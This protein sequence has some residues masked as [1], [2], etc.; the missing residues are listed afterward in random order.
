MAISFSSPT[1]SGNSVSVI[2]TSDVAL[3][4]VGANDFSL[5]RSDTDVVVGSSADI[6]VSVEPRT[7]SDYKW[8]ITVTNSANYQGSVYIRARA[9]GFIESVSRVNVPPSNLDSST[10][11]F[12]SPP[13]PVDVAGTYYFIQSGGQ[14]LAYDFDDSNATTRNSVKDRDFRTLVNGSD[15][16]SATLADTPNGRRIG[17]IDNG[18]PRAIRV[19]NEDF[20]RDTTMDVT[21]RLSAGIYT[22]LC[23]T[24]DGW[25]ASVWD[26]GT[27]RL[28]FYSYA[29]VEDAAKRQAP[30]NRGNN[31]L[32]ADDTHI[33]IVSNIDDAVY[34]RTFASPTITSFIASLGTGGWNGGASTSDRFVLVDS[35]G[36]KGVFYNHS[37]TLQSSEEISLPSAGY[38]SVLAIESSAS[39]PDP[40]P[41]TP[42]SLSAVVVDHDT[43][44][45]TIGSS[46]GTVTA[47]QYRYATSTGALASATWQ[48][49]SATTID[50]DGLSPSTL[51]YFQARAG[52]NGSWSAPST[53]AS[54]T[55][56]AARVVAPSTPP[57]LRVEVID[58]DSVRL[59]IGTPTGTVTQYQYRYATS[60]SGLSSATWRDGGTAT[61]IQIDGLSPNTLYYF[62]ARAG[63]QGQFSAATSTATGTT[64]APPPAETLSIENIDEQF[65]VLGTTD[66]VLEIDIGGSPDTVDATGH[67]EGFNVNWDSARQKVY[68]RAESVTRLIGGVFWRVIAVKGAE[69]LE[70]EIKYNVIPPGTIFH[71]LEL[72][73]LYR[74]VLINFD[75][76]IEN[77]PP[78]LIPD[79]RLL[80]LKSELLESGISAGGEIP[81]DSVFASDKGAIEVIAPL[82]TGAIKREY[83]YQLEEGDPPPMNT[84]TFR[85]Q[86]NFGLLDFDPVKHA[87]GYEWTLGDVNADTIWNDTRPVVNPREIEVTPGNLQVSVKFP[88]VPNASSYEYRLDSEAHIV[89]WTA[90]QGILENGFIGVVIPGL[91]D[92]VE[93]DLS[94]RVGSPWIGVPVPIKVYGG[95]LCY[96]LQ[97]NLSDRSN[98]WLY[99]F[100][101]GFPHATQASRVK[102][103]LLPTALTYPQSGG[104]A[105]NSDGDVFIGNLGSTSAVEKAIYTFLSD[106]IESAADGSRLTQDR[107]N[108]F[109]SSFHPSYTLSGMAEYNGDLYIYGSASVPAWSKLRVVPLPQSDGVELTTT[110][111]SSATSVSTDSAVMSATDESIWLTDRF[112]TRIRPIP[113]DRTLFTRG[114]PVELYWEDGTTSDSVGNGLKVI[115][116]DFYNILEGARDRL[117]IFRINPG[118]HPTRHV[119]DFWLALPSGLDQPRFLDVL[120]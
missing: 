39:I 9:A 83:N 25:V 102:R 22:A 68:I 117:E 51:Y 19:L 50:V 84:P 38:D 110:G 18:S 92:G 118:V 76:I 70:A 75:I 10:F 106:T 65:I 14:G 94:I 86:G 31:G 1:V 85:P 8:D 107:K 119:L 5:R 103:L 58:E 16:R 30:T 101:T 12:G 95:R 27:W 44:K 61:T 42:A 77:L 81:V 82:E 34:R 20:S 80:G 52:N 63:N 28:E 35:T 88:I 47:R 21:L 73:H 97:L 89:E 40:A 105:V 48:D 55:T 120:V 93:Y 98:Q 59:I 67:M 33:Y 112:S 7:G 23:A 41:S 36:N 91:Q 96:T 37:G 29:G 15:V 3:L 4:S 26:S 74:R 57:T 113:Y 66:Y 90:F 6:S 71:E 69:K 87:L 24:P 62:Q 43:I 13:A 46:T 49:A 32:F 115:G 111:G 72:V 78:L 104:L 17:V 54:A 53:T 11:Q 99:I 114:T 116:D 45:L 56:R 100:H 2:M 108:P 64:S 60:S 79:A 109:P